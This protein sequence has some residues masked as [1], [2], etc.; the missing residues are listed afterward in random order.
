MTSLCNDTNIY[1]LAI[2][3]QHIVLNSIFVQSLYWHRM[4]GELTDGFRVKFPEI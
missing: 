2:L 3:E 4:F 1:A